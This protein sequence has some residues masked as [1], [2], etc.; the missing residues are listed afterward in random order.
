MKSTYNKPSRCSPPHGH[1]CVMFIL[2]VMH[3]ARELLLF[4]SPSCQPWSLQQIRLLQLA[5]CSSMP[6]VP[7][8]FSGFPLPCGHPQVPAVTLL[9]NTESVGPQSPVE[10]L[11]S[12]YQGMM[13]LPRLARRFTTTIWPSVATSHSQ[14]SPC[15][16]TRRSDTVS[17]AIVLYCHCTRSCAC[18]MSCAMLLMHREAVLVPFAN[19]VYCDCI[20]LG[21][22]QLFCVV[23]VTYKF[24]ALMQQAT[25]AH[26]SR[27]KPQPASSRNQASNTAHSTDTSW[28]C[29]AVITC[30]MLPTCQRRRC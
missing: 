29:S 13:P 28:F 4:A 11:C 15:S 19:D 18:Q 3:V 30:L 8:F 7:A 14:A 5:R 21:Q 17:F 2:Q 12:A 1:E 23:H 20:Q 25:P 9:H 24:S 26:C 10:V 6:D 27:H 16:K 22:H